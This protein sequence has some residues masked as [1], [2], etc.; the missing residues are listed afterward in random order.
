MTQSGISAADRASA[1]I[2]DNLVRF[3]VGIE[4]IDDILDDF[5][6]ALGAV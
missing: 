4:D 3:C 1:G 6:Q 5:E 2:S